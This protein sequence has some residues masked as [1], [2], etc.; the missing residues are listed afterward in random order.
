[1]LNN[2]VKLFDTIIIGGAMAN[3]FLYSNNISIGISLVEKNLSEDAK[4]IQVKAKNYNCKLVLPVDAVCSNNTKDKDNIHYCEI[5][6][7]LH[8][9][10]ILDIGNKTINLIKNEILNSKM[11]LWNGPL[12]AFEFKPF[13]QGTT[14]VAHTIKMFAKNLKINSIVGGGDTI[15]S[16]KSAKAEN[17]FTYISNAGGAFLEWLEGKESPGI[18]ALKKNNI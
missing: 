10:M 9:K 14:E 8:D 16:I 6:E 15:S 4:K 13:D 17:G 12:G 5:K 18:R 2:L 1:M 7:V 3:T 11:I